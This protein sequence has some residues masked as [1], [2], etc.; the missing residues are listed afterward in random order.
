[1]IYNHNNPFAKIL[2]K[3][4]NCKIIFENKTTLAFQDIK[5]QKKI[6]VLI[7]PKKEYYSY[8]E[9]LD[10]ASINEIG[11]FFL[12]ISKITTKLNIHKKGYRMII[13]HAEWGGQEINHFHVHILSGEN[14]G[15]MVIK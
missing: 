11:L 8:Q 1:M 2:R 12:T 4:I 10:K 13:N 7:I 15:P 9:F 6:H 5:P 14:I 3:E